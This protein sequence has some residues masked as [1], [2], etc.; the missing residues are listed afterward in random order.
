MLEMQLRKDSQGSLPEKT[1]LQKRLEGS[2]D[3]AT[4][5]SEGKSVQA[6]ETANTEAQRQAILFD[7]MSAIFVTICLVL[8]DI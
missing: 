4:W 6:E 8:Y 3:S 2:E 5:S 7:K 1:A